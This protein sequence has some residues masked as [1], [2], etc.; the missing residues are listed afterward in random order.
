MSIVESNRSGDGGACGAG[1]DDIDFLPSRETVLV[2]SNS[3]PLAGPGGLCTPIV[4]GCFAHIAPLGF[5]GGECSCGG[6]V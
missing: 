3:D 2:A 6:C 5:Q 1:R 4:V